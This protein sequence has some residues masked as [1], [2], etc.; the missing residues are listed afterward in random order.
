MYTRLINERNR[1]QTQLNDLQQQIKQ[2][3]EGELLC[4]RNGK[5]IK[6]FKSNGKNP[7]YIPKKKR[8]FA[9]ALAAKKYCSQQIEELSQKIKLLDNFLTSYQKITVRSEELLKD[10]SNY[11]NL[12]RASIQSMPEQL[13][14]WNNAEYLHNTNY[15]EHL[16]HK[17]MAGHNVRSKSEVI[18]ANSLYL[19][20]IPYR[21]ECGV[22]FDNVALYPDFTIC[23]PK[24]MEI[25]YWEHFGMMSNSSYCENTFNKLKIYGNHGIIPSINLI[26]TFETQEHPIDSEKIQKLI[27]E[28]FL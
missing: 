24:T 8:A 17:S 18:I 7:V 6:W 25:F 14:E 3:P 4:V 22:L 15:P 5:Y 9:E 26:T 2:F 21:Y 13:N 16:I 12:L 10:T 28:Y 1:Y 27:D 20:K 11:Q 19:N 23:H